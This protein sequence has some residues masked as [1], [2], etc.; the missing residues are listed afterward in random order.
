MRL[1]FLFLFSLNLFAL[2]IDDLR[3]SFEKEGPFVAGRVLTKL[4]N[5]LHFL[6]NERDFQNTLFATAWSAFQFIESK[7]ILQEISETGGHV[8]TGVKNQKKRQDLVAKKWK[9]LSE[10]K[11]KEYAQITRAEGVERKKQRIIK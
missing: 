2:N 3:T 7:A 6:E 8:P 10:D 5:G 4:N 11:K 9:E 1:I